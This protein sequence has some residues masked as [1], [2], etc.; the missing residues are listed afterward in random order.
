M[1]QGGLVL[2]HRGDASERYLC[3]IGFLVVAI[4]RRRNDSPGGSGILW[5]SPQRDMH[6]N[7]SHIFRAVFND[8]W[9][10]ALHKILLLSVYSVSVIWVAH[11]ISVRL[12]SLV[13]TWWLLLR[14]ETPA[15]QSI[16]IIFLCDLWL[17]VSCYHVHYWFCMVLKIPASICYTTRMR[18]YCPAMRGW[19]LT[20]CPGRQ[21]IQLPT[22][23]AS[24]QASQSLCCIDF[25]LWTMICARR[26]LKPPYEL[27]CAYITR[28]RTPRYASGAKFVLNTTVDR[29]C[30]FHDRK[31]IKEVV[32]VDLR[33]CVL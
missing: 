3:N 17:S 14:L 32:M 11:W 29:E 28:G 20:A 1:R 7:V 27:K 26:S 18:F 19:R 9:N 22:S 24:K 8:L 31:K 13:L 12:S 15:A 33:T 2:S 25:V 4:E 30:F 6:T 23:V 21:F 5:Y 10:D 16:L